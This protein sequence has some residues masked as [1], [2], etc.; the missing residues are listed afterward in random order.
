MLYDL[1]V[2]FVAYVRCGCVVWVV[3]VLFF[4][5]FVIVSWLWCGCVEVVS[6]LF[7]ACV[8]LV[9]WLCSVALWVFVFVMHGV[10]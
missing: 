7:C 10:L 4:F 1:C 5:L 9:L 3:R 8:V 6:R 2:G